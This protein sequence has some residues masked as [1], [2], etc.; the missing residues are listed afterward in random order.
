MTFPRYLTQKELEA[1]VDE[2]VMDEDNNNESQHIDAVYIPPE[3]DTLTDEEDINDNINLQEFGEPT[4]IVRTFELHT[5]NDTAVLQ[6]SCNSSTTEPE[7]D[8]ETL[9]FKRTFFK[10]QTVK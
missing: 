6:Q 8:D 7:W 1:A 3:V 4:D 5:P 9:E 10:R 2:I